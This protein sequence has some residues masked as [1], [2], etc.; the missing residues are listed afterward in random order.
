M[1]REREITVATPHRKR[2]GHARASDEGR[3]AK[4]RRAVGLGRRACFVSP[5]RMRA[6]THARPS[7]A[8]KCRERK[9]RPESGP[10]QRRSSPEHKCGTSRRLVAA[11]NGLTECDGGQKIGEYLIVIT[12]PPFDRNQLSPKEVSCGGVGQPSQ[13]GPEAPYGRHSIYT[14]RPQSGHLLSSQLKKKKNPHCRRHSRRPLLAPH[15]IEYMSQLTLPL[16]IEHF[17]CKL[18]NTLTVWPRFLSQKKIREENAAAPNLHIA[19]KQWAGLLA[20]LRWAG[21]IPDHWSSSVARI[22]RVRP[23]RTSH[24]ARVMSVQC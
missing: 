21:S 9:E 7:A 24:V 13:L 18:I 19:R 6:R 14:R 22:N 10:E 11:E 4:R 20:R 17:I 15:R 16:Y 1:A 2:N 3:P 8:K 12:D 23:Y 5:D